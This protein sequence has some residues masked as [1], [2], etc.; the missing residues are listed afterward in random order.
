MSPTH[1]TLRVTPTHEFLQRRIPSC[2]RR[3]SVWA[4]CWRPCSLCTYLSR[5]RVG[6]PLAA[7]NA[8]LLVDIQ[9]RRQV[10][11][12]LREGGN[13]RALSSMRSRLRDLHA[14]SRGVAGR[15]GRRGAQR[16][17]LGEIIGRH[18]RPLSPR[19]ATTSR[20]SSWSRRAEFGSRKNLASAQDGTL[21]RRRHHSAIRDEDPWGFP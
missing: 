12:A 15:S 3:R 21:L 13:A 5:L 7:T 2:R 20:A 10:E 14:R 9:A 16:L 11:Q 18:F 6:A 17:R 4:P 1:W 19:P 8:R